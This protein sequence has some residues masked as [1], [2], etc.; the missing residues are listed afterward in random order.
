MNRA[1]LKRWA[2]RIVISIACV[3]ALLL[4][5]VLPIGA[6]FL[7]TNSRF[8]FP[9]RGPKTAEEVGLTVSTVDFMS[10]DGIPLRGWWSEGD[11]SM[12]VILF[13]HGLNRSRVEMLERA[14]DANHR[15]Y[16]VLLFDLRN[17]GESG[18]AYTTIGV[19]ESRDVCGAST[20][21]KQQAANRAQVLWGV[22]MGASSAILAARQCPGV[23]AIVSDSSFLS[24]RDTINHHLKLFFRL[25]SFPIANLIIGITAFRIGFDPDEGDVEAAV[26]SLNIPI[27][28]IAGGADRRMPPALAERMSKE[29]PN[30][31]TRLLI[32][33]DAT[34]GEAFRED[35]ERYLNSVYQ[36][37]QSVR[38]NPASFPRAG[39]S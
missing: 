16:G 17:H 31:A 27:L 25:P 11:P 14:A 2:I 1:A 13:V 5:V 4:F 20:W 10:S 22:S 23:S 28:F 15:G 19:F 38:Y 26:R 30:A 21:V 12:P 36:F 3:I 39:G 9:E 6:S 37:L 7:I 35:R 8:R 24:F 32:I 29:S 18:K 34:H 33:P